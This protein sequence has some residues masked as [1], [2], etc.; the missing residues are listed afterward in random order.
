[1]LQI[2]EPEQIKERIYITS[3]NYSV[4]FVSSILFKALMKSDES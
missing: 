3:K 1:M 2:N 4:I